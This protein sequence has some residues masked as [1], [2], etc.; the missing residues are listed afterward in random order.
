MIKFRLNSRRWGFLVTALIITILLAGTLAGCAPAGNGANSKLLTYTLSEPL[1]GATAAKFDISTESGN[2]TIDMLAGSEPVL[3]SGAL[4]YL[5]GQALPARSLTTNDGQPTLTL[6]SSDNQQ[7][8]SRF[9]WEACNG[10]T[11]W[12]VHLNPSVLSDIVAHSGGGNVRLN[13]AGMKVTRVSADT[14]GGNMEVVLP[15]NAA[16]LSVIAKSGAGDVTI[17]IGSGITGSSTIETSSGAGNVSIRLPGGTAA[18]I[19]TA[20]GMG[21]VTVDRQYSKVNDNTYQSPDYDSAADRIEISVNS[22][23]GNINISTK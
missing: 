14:G 5:E 18:R 13:L 20:G 2:L 17:E 22:G 10:A 7:A 9:P 21:K 3:A 1:A 12:Q 15:D 16:N 19:R 8:G 4:Q 6:K 23:A 11:E